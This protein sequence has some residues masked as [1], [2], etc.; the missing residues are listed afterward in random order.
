M[1]V[2]LTE[3]SSAETMQLSG[4]W[5]VSQVLYRAVLYAGAFAL[6]KLKIHTAHR[7]AL[8]SASALFVLSVLTANLFF[9]HCIRTDTFSAHFPFTLANF[10]EVI[11]LMTLASALFF[12]A[13]GGRLRALLCADLC[14]RGPFAFESLPTSG[15]NPHLFATEKQ[16]R[17]LHRLRSRYGCHHCGSKNSDVATVCDHI[18]P[19]KYARHRSQRMLFFPQCQR[20]STLQSTA[21]AFDRQSLLLSSVV[22][23]SRRFHLFFPSALILVAVI[24]YGG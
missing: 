13:M 7:L 4:A 20:C 15:T 1:H 2:P 21:C 3:F 22:Q 18:P 8:V 11:P 6:M 23:G 24:S 14:E 9:L 17:E 12:F 5:L 10:V 19:R 16:R